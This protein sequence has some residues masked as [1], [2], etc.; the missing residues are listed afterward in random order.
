MLAYTFMAATLTTT[1]IT[2]KPLSGAR[3][4]D[5]KLIVSAS[6]EKPIAV[7][8]A[9]SHVLLS[10]GGLQQ[11]SLVPPAQLKAV[12][13]EEKVVYGPASILVLPPGNYTIYI[14]PTV[15]GTYVVEISS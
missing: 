10:V 7:I 12:E 8:K 4:E 14:I 9:D 2:V 5:G 6:A 15:P 3:L 13:I 1:T 11:I